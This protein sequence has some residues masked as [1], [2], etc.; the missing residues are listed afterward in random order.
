MRFKRTCRNHPPMPSK[1]RQ[2]LRK[3]KARFISTFPGRVFAKFVGKY[4]VWRYD[5]YQLKWKLQKL[6]Y[7][8]PEEIENVRKNVTFIFK[9]FERQEMAKRLCENIQKYYPGAQVIVADDSRQPLTIS[10]PNVQVIQLPF[11][12]GISRGLNAALSQVKTPYTMRLDDDIL[13]TPFSQIGNQLI[14]LQTHPEITLS[15]VLLCNTISR[16]TC[17][18]TA[19]SYFLLNQKIIKMGGMPFRI[20]PVD[21]NHYLLLKTCNTFLARTEPFRNLGYD[22]NIRMIDHAEFFHRAQNQF[23]CVMDLTACVYH[24]HNSFDAHY[25]KYRSDYYG[26]VIYIRQKHNRKQNN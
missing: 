2:L 15:A 8:A 19:T 9:S 22:D 21:T 20:A 14:F 12:S 13:L 7:P 3:I 17:Q 24:Y 23:L 5:L 4:N 25:G 1:F 11:N 6:P 18:A 10:T 16:K 26:D